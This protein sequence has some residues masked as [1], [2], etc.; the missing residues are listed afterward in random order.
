[1]CCPFLDPPRR[2]D[3]RTFHPQPQ[4]PRALESAFFGR[5]LLILT[6]RNPLEAHLS[7]IAGEK[8]AEP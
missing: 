6:N 3:S 8:G 7:R 1:M 4:P 5:I 2:G